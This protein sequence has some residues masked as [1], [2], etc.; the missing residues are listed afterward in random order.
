M[1]LPSRLLRSSLAHLFM[2]CARNI[3]LPS[4]CH[5]LLGLGGRSSPLPP[6]FRTRHPV[7]TTCFLQA[8]PRSPKR[9]SLRR[10]GTFNWGPSKRP[11]P[12]FFLV[13]S[14]KSLPFFLSCLFFHFE[15]LVPCG[16]DPTTYLQD[17]PPPSTKLR[18]FPKS[19][20]F[21]LLCPRRIPRS[22]FPFAPLGAWTAR[23]S[24]C[25]FAFCSPSAAKKSCFDR[26]PI[27]RLESEMGRHLLLCQR[28]IPLPPSCLLL[29]RPASIALSPP[30]SF[31]YRLLLR[32]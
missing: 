28:D 27:M 6:L 4:L 17:P 7:E 26:G 18:G 1:C 10:R 19:A 12:F 3:T 21:S 15:R 9:K 25:A 32:P 8:S 5:L 20:F 29:S 2:C 31:L 14:D 16:N 13:I 22:T 23:L 24:T 30:V 11:P